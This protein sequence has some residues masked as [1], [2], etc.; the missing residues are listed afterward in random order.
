MANWQPEKEGCHMWP[1]KPYNAAHQ[2][3][4]WSHAPAPAPHAVCS[5]QA[6]LPVLHAALGPALI[7]WAAHTTPRDTTWHTQRMQGWTGCACC[8]GGQHRARASTPCQPPCCRQHA[9]I[10]H[11]HILPAACTGPRALCMWPLGQ[12]QSDAAHS[13]WTR[14]S[15]PG[16]TG[17]WPS[18]LHAACVPKA[19]EG[20]VAHAGLRG[21][22]VL[23]MMLDLALQVLHRGPKDKPSNTHPGHGVKWVWHPCLKGF[24]VT[25]G[26]CGNLVEHHCSNQRKGNWF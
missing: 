7:Q 5:M 14:P 26:S 3:V 11:L 21:Q 4:D 22:C 13:M 10:V 8:T 24:Q 15:A 16:T 19:T 2:L 12:A 1:M 25:P 9:R 18:M 23:H 20:S 6:G 17:S